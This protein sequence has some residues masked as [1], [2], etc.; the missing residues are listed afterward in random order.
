MENRRSKRILIT[1]ATGA[2]GGHL[3]K[4]L[5]EEGHICRCLV[6]KTSKIEN[7]KK[8]EVEFVYGD[9]CDADSLKGITRDIDIVFHLAAE[10]H[11]S[12]SSKAAYIKFQ[13]VNVEGTENLL[14]ECQNSEI[15]KFIHF[16]S[17][18]AM[19][20]I[21]NVVADENTDCVPATPYQI[22]KY[23]SEQ[24]AINMWY[25]KGL[26]VVVLRPCMVYGE[27]CKGEY[28]RIFN[29]MKRGIFPKLGRG[30]KLTP[31]INVKNLIDSAVNAMESGVPGN[32]YLL[33]DQS[34]EIDVLRKKVL[35]ILSTDSFYPY[36]PAWFGLILVDCYEK[37]SKI[38]GIEP[39]ITKRN[40]KSTIS[41][42][43]FSTAKAEKDLNYKRRVSLD[44]GLKETIKWAM[45]NRYL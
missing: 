18:A 38:L 16:S 32:V 40:I 12:S 7:L 20:L 39:K 10:G 2:I 23:Q 34:V 43:I 25:D 5:R 35:N 9:I 11:V 21:E 36:L 41:D 31:L 29:Y 37:I 45:A 22:A 42:R 28:L 44:E 24:T 6:R 13:K 27:G 19:G 17:T 3:V 8:Y 14:R 30:K 1:G 4:R 26:P 33:I 15:N